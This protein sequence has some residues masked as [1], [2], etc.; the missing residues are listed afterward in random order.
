MPSK[1]SRIAKGSVTL[2][3]NWLLQNAMEM[4]EQTVD[5]SSE[6]EWLDI[7]EDGSLLH[8]PISAGAIHTMCVVSLLEQIV[9]CDSLHVMTEWM[10]AWA[11]ESKQVDA[12]IRNKIVSG[13]RFADVN[14]DERTE[15]Y[16]RTLCR[17]DSLRKITDE[18]DEVFKAGSSHFVGQAFNGTAPYLA[19]ADLTGYAYAPHPVRARI[20]EKT[21]YKVSPAFSPRQKLEEIVNTSRIKLQKRIGI[22]S[23]VTSLATRMPS[24][25]LMCLSNS[26]PTSPPIETAIQLRDSTEFRS[27]RSSLHEM[28]KALAEDYTKTANVYLDQVHALESAVRE[29]ERRLKL[30]ELDNGDGVAEIDVWRGVKA[31]VP[32]WLRRPVF[33]PRHT[34]A[35]Y[36]LVTAKS[37]DIRRLLDRSLGVTDP[38]I[39]EDLLNFYAE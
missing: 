32:S 11:G 25:A 14:T 13:F 22:D 23:V 1:T 26:S 31:R 16:R 17:S 4:L 34:T 5:P 28:Q 37:T 27:L 9:F 35:V 2:T 38:R 33:P 20:L 21:L 6:A 30:R 36:R 29:V 24:I 10:D 12:L 15:N 39:V 19:Q 3:D 7:S 8:R 18:A